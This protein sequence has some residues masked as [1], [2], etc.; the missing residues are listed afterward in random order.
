FDIPAGVTFS[1]NFFSRW[2][3]YRHSTQGTASFIGQSFGGEVEDYLWSFGP[4]AVTLANLTARSNPTSPSSLYLGLIG[5]LGLTALAGTA[6][7]R[8]RAHRG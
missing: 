7:L 1:T 3:L 6:W 2:R 4:T 5:A 8:R